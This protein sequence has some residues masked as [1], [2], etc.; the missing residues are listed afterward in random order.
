MGRGGEGTGRAA[1]PAC[2]LGLVTQLPLPPPS[3]HHLTL[4]AFSPMVAALGEG[5]ELSHACLRGDLGPRS[6]SIPEQPSPGS[7]KFPQGDLFK[8]SA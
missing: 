7:L 2:Q 8:I 4:R 3:S 5:V 1:L 6:H